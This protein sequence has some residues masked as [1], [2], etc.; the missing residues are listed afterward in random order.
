MKLFT[1]AGVSKLNGQ[2]KA[3]FANDITRVKVLDKNGHTD[4]NL[5]ELPAAMDKETAVEHL[6]TLPAFSTDTAIL[7]AMHSVLGNKT[8]AAP[9]A[10]E[11]ESAGDAEEGSDAGAAPE[12]PADDKIIELPVAAAKPKRNRTTS[13]AAKQMEDWAAAANAEEKDEGKG[14]DSEEVAA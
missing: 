7:A 14:T 9:A 3:R 12:E 10:D 6:L 2:F 13:A 4:I 11:P 8:P 1:V 5:I